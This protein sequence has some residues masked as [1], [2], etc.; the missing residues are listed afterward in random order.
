MQ[1]PGEGI[2]NLLFKNSLGP[3][4][5]R[6][7]SLPGKGILSLFFAILATACICIAGMHDAFISNLPHEM[8]FY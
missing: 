5:V 7:I 2:A 4:P 6:F 8:A 3:G 1:Q